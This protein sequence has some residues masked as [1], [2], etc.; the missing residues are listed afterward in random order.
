MA[1]QTMKAIKNIEKGKAEIQEVPVPKLLDD[2][3][4]VKVRAV[5][6]NPTDWKHVDFLAVPGH[7]VGCD[8]AGVVEEVGSKVTKDFKKGD[9]IAGFAHGV[10]SRNPEHG[11][12]GEFCLAKGDLWMKVPDNVTDEEAAT[13][14]VG[15]S[16]VGQGLY[17]SLGLPLPGSG[18]KAGYSILIYGGSTATGSLAIQY[19]VLSGCDVITTC[20]ERNFPFVKSLGASA[21]FDYKDPDVAKK[22]REHTKDQLAYAFDCMSEKDSAKICSEAIGSKGGKVSFLLP[23]KPTRDDVESAVTMAYTMM[24]EQFNM[25]PREF[26]ANPQDLEFGKEFWELSTKLVTSKQISVHPPHIGKDGL[27]GVFDGLQQLKEGKVSGQKLVYR[28]NETP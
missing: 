3:C 14:G 17:Q 23:V 25:G 28:V 9:R 21:A 27:K 12:F 19:A 13:L 8:F 26:P 4:L 16:T 18:Q 1:P 11:A 15:I 24:G 5:A 2:Y 20:S 22:I 7:T 6:L 10:S